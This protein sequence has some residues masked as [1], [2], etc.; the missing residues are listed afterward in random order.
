MNDMYDSLL[1]ALRQPIP[2]GGF[3]FE[4][5]DFPMPLAD[6]VVF[7]GLVLDPYRQRSFGFAGGSARDGEPPFEILHSYPVV[8]WFGLRESWQWL[9]LWLLHLVF[10][11]R[12][13]AGLRLGH[14]RNALKHLYVCCE[15]TDSRHPLLMAEAPLRYSACTYRPRDLTRHPFYD[16]PRALDQADV[17]GFYFGWSD[18]NA[19]P[20]RR[21]AEAD[22]LI[23]TATSEGLCEL[24]L[25]FLDFGSPDNSRDEI[26]LEVPVLGHR[27]AEVRF[28]LPG[29]FA[30]PER[31]LD[32]VYLLSPDD[33]TV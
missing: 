6:E 19:G 31:S 26:N 20:R 13:W 5:T 4:T 3:R 25:L 16:T 17:P 27:S 7:G 33:M 9:G 21:R 12:G 22:Q 28:W 15:R 18:M 24:A 10:S 11:G 14:P 30:F 29:S 1:D 23:L 2:R 32:D 8:D